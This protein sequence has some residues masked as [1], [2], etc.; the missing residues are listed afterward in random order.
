MLETIEF[1]DAIKGLASANKLDSFAGLLNGAAAQASAADVATV[2]ADNH[3]S[4][5]IA[6]A[7][8]RQPYI[9]LY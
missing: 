6:T 8:I 5:A 2:V 7:T 3:L 9:T 4:A 1:S